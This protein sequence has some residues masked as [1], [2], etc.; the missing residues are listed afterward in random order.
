MLC[1]DYNS[2]LFVRETSNTDASSLALDS[3]RD[4]TLV[5]RMAVAA[6]TIGNIQEYRPENELF[7][8]YTERV[9]LFFKANSI[10]NDKKL[11]HS[12]V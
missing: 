3:P 8:S 9:E 11:L 2:I 12:S 7:S 4:T 10:A 6:T 5:T 1:H